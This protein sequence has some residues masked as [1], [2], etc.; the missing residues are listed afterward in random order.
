M[1]KCGNCGAPIRTGVDECP[2][3]GVPTS[4]R[5]RNRQTIYKEPQFTRHQ[6]EALRTADWLA[7]KHSLQGRRADETVDAYVSRIN[8]ES[9]PFLL[10]EHK[11]IIEARD[12]REQERNAASKPREPGEEG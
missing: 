9:L 7:R 2:E 10:S 5:D 12:R 4:G 3:C 8:E 1:S 6:E 11:R